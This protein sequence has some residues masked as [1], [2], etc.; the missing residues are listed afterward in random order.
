M[1]KRKR[2]G[3]PNYYARRGERA[4]REAAA[5]AEARSLEAVIGRLVDDMNLEAIT[6]GLTES[7][8]RY[9]DRTE[10][11]TTV[12]LWLEGDP[13]SREGQSGT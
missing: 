10:G 1:G 13:E 12:P 2:G 7:F 4:R 6:R 3:N 11:R 5:A 8:D 9:M